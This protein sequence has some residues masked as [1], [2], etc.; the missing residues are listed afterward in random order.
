MPIHQD[1]T[2]TTTQP[3]VRRGFSP[4]QNHTLDERGQST[5]EF[6][7]TFI[8]VFITLSDPEPIRDQT[9]IQVKKMAEQQN[10]SQ[11]EFTQLWRELNE[12]RSQVAQI[13]TSN[14]DL[15]EIKH[16]LLEMENRLSKG[17]NTQKK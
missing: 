4:R 7:L 16:K 10:Q 5:I 15:T 11:K 1:M 9:K 12:I 2:I 17:K 8:F 13:S 14:S 6:L 3:E